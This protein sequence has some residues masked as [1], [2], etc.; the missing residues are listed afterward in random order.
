[1]KDITIMEESKAVIYK[2]LIM[3]ATQF[4]LKGDWKKAISTNKEIL[5]LNKLDVQ[6]L[7]RIGKA[8]L[9]LG[10]LKDSKKSYTKALQ[11]DPLNTIA[12]RNLKELEQMKDA[13]TLQGKAQNKSNLEKLVRNDILIQTAARSAEFII[14]K[15]NSRAI[16]NLVPG[17][18]LLIQASDSG[19][20]ITNSRKVAL[21]TIEPRSALRLKTCIEGGSQFEVIFKDFFGHSGVIQILEIYREPSITLKTPFINSIIDAERSRILADVMLYSEDENSEL[22]L[23]DNWESIDMSD[24]DEKV[25]EENLQDG[26]QTIDTS[27]DDDDEDEEEVATG[28]IEE[29]KDEEI[30]DQVIDEASKLEKSDEESEEKSDEESEEKSDE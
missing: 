23:E 1:M 30:D 13:K 5:S 22:G 10:K 25:E 7:N 8:Q 20:E 26:F 29:A 15:P 24:D 3:D 17:V 19:V 4:A 21:G 9:E 6:A 2:N 16:Q 27:N 14:D 12:R 18:E 11:I 28:Q